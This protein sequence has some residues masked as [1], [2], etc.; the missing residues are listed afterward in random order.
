MQL[1]NRSIKI[2]LQSFRSQLFSSSSKSTSSSVS[3]DE[4]TKFSSMA[5]SW[6]ELDNNPL[7]TMN[8]VRMS[9][10]EETLRSNNKILNYPLSDIT[11]YDPLKGLK[12]LDVGCG[13]GLLSESLARLGAD[14]TAIDPSAEVADAAHEHSKLDPCTRQ[15]EYRGGISVEEMANEYAKENNQGL[16]DIVCVLEVIE[17]ASDPQSLI[18]NAA[19]L[20]KKPTSD[21]CTGGML[22][23]ST[24]NRT[25]KSYALA[26]VGG[27][28]VMRKLPVGTHSWM[29]FKSPQEV[30]SLIRDCGLSQIDVNGMVLS[31]PF[32]DMRWKLDPE[33]VDINWIGAYSH[34]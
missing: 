23:I 9:F 5:A 6:W 26:I 11:K 21:N 32:F 33:D 13:G 22:F 7:I 17:H 20:L 34:K 28:F 10:I 27:E 15:I 18:R 2:P 29:K 8:P 3:E 30:H 14:V 4:V 19:S 25:A 24:I 31:P 12:A 16:F 1:I